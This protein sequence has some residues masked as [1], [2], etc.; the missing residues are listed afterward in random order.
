MMTQALV[1]GG[2]PN[3]VDSGMVYSSLSLLSPLIYQ[4]EVS[5]CRFNQRMAQDMCLRGFLKLVASPIVSSWL[6]RCFPYLSISKLSS[7]TVVWYK[8]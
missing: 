6:S 7:L 2:L 5:I 4:K 1:S 8:V 3:L